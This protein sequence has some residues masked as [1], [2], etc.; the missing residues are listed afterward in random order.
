MAAVEVFL[1][2][3]KIYSYEDVYKEQGARRLWIE[4]PEDSSGKAITLR[5]EGKKATAA[6]VLDSPMYLGEKNA[7]LLES[8][9]GGF[10]ALIFAF[11]TF[12]LAFI[13]WV[14]KIVFGMKLSKN[15][16]KK[17]RYLA[18]FIVDTG[19]WVLTDSEILQFF[20]GKTAVVEIVSFLTFLF[21]PVFALLFIKEMM[22][23]HW[24]IYDVLLK[25]SLVNIVIISGVYL[26]RI[27]PIYTFL[28]LQHLLI[29]F[30]I[31]VILKTGIT[32][33]KKYKNAA[34]KKIIA[35]FGMMSLSVIAALG[36]FYVNVSINYAYLYSIGFV[37]FIMFLA[38]SAF[39]EVYSHL[40]ENAKTEVYRKMA[41]IDGMTGMENRAAFEKVLNE[42]KVAKKFTYIMFD[43]NNLK[44]INDTYG[45]QAGDQLLI[46]TAE[47]I[48]GVFGRLGRCFR[49]GGDEFVV[50]LREM[51]EKEVKESLGYFDWK[52]EEINQKRKVRIEV[53]YGYFTC[54]DTSMTAEE[55]FKKA[56]ANMYSKKQKMK[57]GTEGDT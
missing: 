38:W 5:I 41:Y 10:Y 33:I 26:L 21:I 11:F 2:G 45:H 9:T 46:E 20:T 44:K 3:E 39:G 49:I 35:G 19:V 23:Y 1:N 43:N 47:C 25:I 40:E 56:D 14:S 52:I 51:S 12:V 24:K 42:E 8:L 17:M 22:V 34:M 16:L 6:R 15:S 31:P 13:I 55:L 28:F 7:V 53:A 36:T 29:L 37:V 30:A 27:A 48:K 57:S 32:E 54:R 18:L 4:F 50:V